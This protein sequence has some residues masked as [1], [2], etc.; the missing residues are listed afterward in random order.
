MMLTTSAMF[1]VG[2][3]ARR[4]VADPFAENDMVTIERVSFLHLYLACICICILSSPV[5]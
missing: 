1:M 3:F 4:A 2:V 5:S